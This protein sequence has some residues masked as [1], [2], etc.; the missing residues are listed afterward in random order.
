MHHLRLFGR[1]H[2]LGPDGNPMPFRTG[3]Q[4]AL[5][6]YLALEARNRPVSRDKLIDLFW[7][8]APPK[9]GR[10]S[11]S[12]ALTATRAKLGHDAVTRARKE[13]QLVARF[14]TDLDP[15]ARSTLSPQDLRNP[16][17]DL[18]QY[19]GH[20]FSLW[21][22][23]VRDRC[24][25]D[26]KSRLLDEVSTARTGG[27]V[28]RVHEVAE[29]LYVIDPHNDVAALAVAEQYVMRGDTGGAIKLLRRHIETATELMRKASKQVTSFLR[30]V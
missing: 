7:P 6:V 11:L 14:T 2:L 5:L 13:V 15:E 17:E 30:R 26:V 27:D 25:A 10:H 8:D 21:V 19:G 18:E 16:L 4:L 12:D 29:Q 28:A 9:F 24:L 3:K 20:Q 1:P 22:D 23:G